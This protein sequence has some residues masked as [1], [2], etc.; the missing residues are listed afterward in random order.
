MTA[1]LA[2]RVAVAGRVPRTGHE[3]GRTRPAGEP[4]VGATAPAE[5]ALELT[6]RLWAGLG[7]LGLGLVTAGVAAGHLARDP[8]AGVALAV[9]GLAVLG[10]AVAALRAPVRAPGAAV[11]A[12]LLVGPAALL[13]AP[14]T[15]SRPTAAEAAALTLGLGTAIAL[16]LG[17]RAATAPGPRR[18]LGAR[19][20][21]GVLATGALLVALV[22]V[23][24]LAAT[25]AGAHAV[26]HGSHGLPAER[27]HTGH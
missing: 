26:P 7:A 5:G 15:Q 14:L 19:G 24:G 17:R 20:Q 10:W 6:A 8:A 22:T 16:A 18:A 21:A 1:A 4:G 3:D 25:E 23:P 12:L 11:G 9:V 2:G 13:A 27:G